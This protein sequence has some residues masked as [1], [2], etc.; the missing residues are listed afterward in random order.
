MPSSPKAPT[1][2]DPSTTA[3]TQAQYNT[4]AAQQT[5]GMNTIGQDNPYGSLNYTTSIDPITGQPK[6]Q[7]NLQYNQTQQALLDQLNQNKSTA[8]GTANDLANNTLGQYADAPDLIGGANSLTMQ[9]LQSQMPAWQRFFDPER[10][11]RRTELI[12]QGITEGNPLYD[13][14][15]NK[16]SANQGQTM[17]SWLSNFEPQAFQQALTNYQTPLSNF[18][19]L[20]GISGPEDLK[21]SLVSTPSAT[22][23]APDYSGQVQNQYNAQLTAQQQKIAQQNSLMN[24][25]LG[26][27]TT[28]LGQPV[29]PSKM[30]FGGQML[31]NIFT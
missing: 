28:L 31:S 12:N 20:M 13:L 16:I 1:Y 4:Q 30:T 25:G 23:G 24:M 2:P 19:T 9:A 5:Q 27:G 11:Q 22:V 26:I 14:E 21:N 17:G 15:M 18:Q 6:Y 10:D 29:N 3:N 8:G 7:A